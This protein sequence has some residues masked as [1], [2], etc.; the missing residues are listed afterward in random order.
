MERLREMLFERYHYLD[1]TEY[2]VKNYRTLLKRRVEDGFLESMMNPEKLRPRRYI[3]YMPTKV[4][5]DVLT[6]RASKGSLR[7]IQD[8]IFDQDSEWC[9]IYNGGKKVKGFHFHNKIIKMYRVTSCGVYIRGRFK[10]DENYYENQKIIYVPESLDELNMKFIGDTGKG[11]E[12]DVELIDNCEVCVVKHI[13]FVPWN[14]NMF[15]MKKQ[16]R[17][18][19]LMDKL[20]KFKKSYITR[21]DAGGNIFEIGKKFEGERGFE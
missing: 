15:N 9:D 11:S 6:F 20:F 13:E 1:I 14:K 21:I 10:M 19:N 7:V 17:D 16:T 5:Y 2:I 3:S 18:M 8:V 4:F 12:L